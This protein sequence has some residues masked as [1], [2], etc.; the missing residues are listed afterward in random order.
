MSSQ[1]GFTLPGS[2][3]RFVAMLIPFGFAAPPHRTGGFESAVENERLSAPSGAEAVAKKKHNP[4]PKFG[5]IPTL[6]RSCIGDVV[7]KNLW[8]KLAVIF[9]S[10]AI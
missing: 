4:A 1:S 6:D 8:S 9:G 2:A 3:G 7:L 5:T 10:M